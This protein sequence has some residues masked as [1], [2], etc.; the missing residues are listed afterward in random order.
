M[1]ERHKETWLA[2]QEMVEFI[3]QPEVER[4]LFLEPCWR[5]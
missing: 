5:Q 4:Q 3:P 2:E 1:K